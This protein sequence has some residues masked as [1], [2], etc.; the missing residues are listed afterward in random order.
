MNNSGIRCKY[1]KDSATAHSAEFT[2]HQ[3]GLTRGFFYAATL[4]RFD[5][6]WELNSSDKIEIPAKQIRQHY[7]SAVDRDAKP[8][9]TENSEDFRLALLAI[10]QQHSFRNYQSP[11]SDRG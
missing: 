5:D 8:V 11:Q 2:R 3:P 7:N 4:G 9:D 1:V 10:G 6:R